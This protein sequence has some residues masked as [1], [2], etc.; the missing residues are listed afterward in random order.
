MLVAAST[1]CFPELSQPDAISKLLDLEYTNVE[2]HF[3][4]NGPGL[5]PSDIANNFNQSVDVALNNHRMNVVSYSLNIAAHGEEFLRQ[6]EACC[7]LA[8]ITK[9][10]TLTVASSELGTPFNEEV[11]KLRDLVAI[12]KLSG[13]RVAIRTEIG[14]M[15]EDIDT[16]HLFCTQCPG[17][18]ITLD[19]S[20]Y[21]VGPMAGRDYSKLIEYVYHVQL[22]D[23]TPEKLQVQIGQGIVDYGKLINQ[24]EGVG[25]EYGLA[26][27]I[28]SQP[29]I[30]HNGEMRKMRLLLESMILG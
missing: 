30:D 29:N 7:K 13:V 6:F 28:T 11:E 18:G 1:E 26:S 22:R 23:S 9:V 17:L 19:P 24:L 4:E 3:C 14:R 8:K 25:Y 27:H 5:K 21:I 2:I 15:S 16:A 20:H 10:V 12:S